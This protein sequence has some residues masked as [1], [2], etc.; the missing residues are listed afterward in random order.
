MYLS[1][2]IE[3]KQVTDNLV[4]FIAKDMLPLSTVDGMGLYRVY[5]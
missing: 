3:R 1:P 4:Q 5:K 2:T